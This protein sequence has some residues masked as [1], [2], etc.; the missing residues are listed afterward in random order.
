VKISKVSS[1]TLV[2]I[3]GSSSGTS[4]SEEPTEEL[5]DSSEDELTFSRDEELSSET[6]EDE[7]SSSGASR[8]ELEESSPQA[9]RPAQTRKAIER[10]IFDT[11]RMIL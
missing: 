5:D 2:R 1:T 6:L 11:W 4:L 7:I 10:K 3:R 8:T 9:T